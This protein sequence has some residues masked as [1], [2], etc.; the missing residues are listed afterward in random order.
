MFRLFLCFFF[1]FI[2]FGL[3]PL[4]VR[5]TT[6]IITFLVGNPYKPSFPLL[7]GGGT[8]QYIFQKKILKKSYFC[9]A[10]SGGTLSQRVLHAEKRL[11]G[12]GP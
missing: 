2:Y 10:K 1:V 8:T 5:V 11:P 3:S 6:R 9:G 7:L 4:P 12:C